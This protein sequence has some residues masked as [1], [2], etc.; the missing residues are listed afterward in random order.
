VP[1]DGACTTGSDCCTSLCVGG[2]CTDLF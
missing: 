1:L 2:R